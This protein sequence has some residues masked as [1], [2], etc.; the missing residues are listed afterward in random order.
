MERARISPGDVADR[1]MASCLVGLAGIERER[2]QPAT[3]A[4][5]CRK[6]LA[7]LVGDP[8]EPLAGEAELALERADAL[9]GLGLALHEL[10]DPEAEMVLR[11]ALELR[12][13]HLGDEDAIWP[14]GACCRRPRRSTGE[15]WKRCGTTPAR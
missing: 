13:Q 14:D 7:L 10:D 12:L 2:G 4:N 9:N 3:A 1:L 6:A 15:R 8:A 5:Q 11:D